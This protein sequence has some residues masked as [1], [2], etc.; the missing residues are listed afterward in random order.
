MA[1]LAL[2]ISEKN[3]SL[4]CVAMKFAINSST[5]KQ[6]NVLSKQNITRDLE[7]KNKLIVT[8]GEVGGDNEGERG[9]VVKE[10]V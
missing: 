5:L 9:R 2:L 4:N 7:I 6:L 10:H 8:R 1:S 3:K